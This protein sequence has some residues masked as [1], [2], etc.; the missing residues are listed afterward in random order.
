MSGVNLA[1]LDASDMLDVLHYMFEDDMRFAS[2]EQAEAISKSRSLLYRQ[3]YEKEYTY[4]FSTGI[5]SVP[6]SIDPPLG[7][8]DASDI[9]P[10]DAERQGSVKPYVPPTKIDENS[11]RPFGTTL[12]APLN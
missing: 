6:A 10:F 7:H 4:R 11:A 12:D 9:R 5:G 1:E 2:A 8:E 3:M